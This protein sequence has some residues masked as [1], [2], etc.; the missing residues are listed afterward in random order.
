MQHPQLPPAAL[1]SHRARPHPKEESAHVLSLQHLTATSHKGF[2]PPQEGALHPA[3]ATGNVA[4]WFLPAPHSSASPCFSLHTPCCS[5]STSPGPTA[6]PE[7][8]HTQ[9]PRALEG[10]SHSP[11]NI[12][13]HQ[14]PDQYP[15][16]SH[17]DWVM[18]HALQP[19]GS[20]EEGKSFCHCVQ[21][22]QV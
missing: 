3:V 19:Y 15:C 4:L 13:V 10:K 12:S 5:C 16:H 8:C 14:Q 6:T 7:R 22:G 18:V 17:K 21:Q 11:L 9:R 20:K 2:P 1:L